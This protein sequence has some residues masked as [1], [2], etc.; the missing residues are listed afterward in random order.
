MF[1]RPHEP[2]SACPD[3]VGD[4]KVICYVPVRSSSGYTGRTRHIIAGVGLGHMDALVI[5]QYPGE[6]GYCLFGC[7]GEWHSITDTWHATL[8]DALAQASFEYEGISS[9]WIYK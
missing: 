1:V 3:T 8:E 6:E 7:D 2:M 4:A 9:A 5:A